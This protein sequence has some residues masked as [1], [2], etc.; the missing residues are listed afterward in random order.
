MQWR[1]RESTGGIFKLDFW[2]RIPMIGMEMVSTTLAMDIAEPMAAA[3]SP[4]EMV[5]NA[6]K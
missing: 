4:T 1:P 2:I 6:L 5:K 3:E